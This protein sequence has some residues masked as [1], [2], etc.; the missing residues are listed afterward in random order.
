M[1]IGDEIKATCANCGSKIFTVQGGHYSSPHVFSCLCIHCGN[2]QDIS[3][4]FKDNKPDM[5]NKPPHYNQGKIEV[6]D[7]IIDQKLDFLAGNIIKYVSRYR[8]KNGVEDLKKAQ[9]YLNKLIEN[10]SEKK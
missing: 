10:E 6:S 1:K 5:V 4:P 7:F 8:F 2:L 3:L 9:W